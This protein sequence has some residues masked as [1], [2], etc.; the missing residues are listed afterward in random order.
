M[1]AILEAQHP[2]ALRAITAD[3]AENVERYRDSGQL[4]VPIAAVIASGTKV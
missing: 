4:A 3:I 2:D 1:A